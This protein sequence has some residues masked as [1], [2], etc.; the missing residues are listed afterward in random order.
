MCLPVVCLLAQAP[1][2]PPA[3]PNAGPAAETAPAAQAAPQRTEV[4]ADKVVLTVGDEKFTRAQIDQLVEALPEQVRTSVRG[5]QKRAFAEQLIRIKLLSQQ[6]RRDGLDQQPL[7]QRQLELNRENVLAQ[8]EF[9]EML[10]NAKVDDAAVKKY[11]DDHKS[12]YE[13][14]KASHILIKVKPATAPAAPPPAPATSGKKELTDEEALAK[15]Q[16]IRKKLVAGEDFAALAKAESDDPGSK[17]KG[18]DLGFIRR[19][20]MVPQFDQAAFTLPVGQLSEPVKTPYGYHVIKVEARQTKPLEEVRADIEKRLRP[21]MARKNIEDMR[22]GGT[23]TVDETFF[24]PA[25]APPAAPMAPSRPTLS[26]APAPA[27][28]K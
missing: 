5:P 9:Q 18:G 15:V 16:E 8:A 3:A 6:A 27:P 22:Q 28:V 13:T 21:E 26:P 24:G 17:D 19:G 20:Q 10:K 14:T 4:P 7:M 11:Y 1:T 25:A 23:V 2:S 12:E